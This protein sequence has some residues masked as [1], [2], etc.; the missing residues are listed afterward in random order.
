MKLISIEEYRTT[1]FA[2]ESKPS[3][4]SLRRLVREGIL[5]GKKLG[6][7]YYINMDVETLHTGNPLVDRVLNGQ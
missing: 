2:G 5:P 1:C 6:K 4:W 3:L 7:G